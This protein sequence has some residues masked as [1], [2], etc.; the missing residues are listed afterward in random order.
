MHCYIVNGVISYPHIGIFMNNFIALWHS[1]N[2][3]KYIFVCRNFV[4]EWNF[5]FEELGNTQLNSDHI[6]SLFDKYLLTL[7]LFCV[8]WTCRAKIP[9]REIANPWFSRT[10]DIFLTRSVINR[11]D[12]FISVAHSSQFGSDSD[13]T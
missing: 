2:R 6:T 13:P 7:L 8:I 1:I 4:I 3:K 12:L 10:P 5:E 9:V 11:L